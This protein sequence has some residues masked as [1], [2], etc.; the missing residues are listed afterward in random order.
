MVTT[1]SVELTAVP[2]PVTT[3]EIFPVVAPAGTVVTILVDVGVPDMIAGVP[4]KLTALFADIV[5][6][7]VPVIV[8]GVASGP[9]AG[10]KLVIVGRG[11]STTKLVELVAVWPATV[12]EIGPVEAVAGTDVVTVV[13]VLAVTLAWTPLNNT[14]LFAGVPLKFVPVIV[15]TVPSSPLSGLKPVIVG[16]VVL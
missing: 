14:I 7:F 13:V 8:T 16:E 9:V 1:K 12:I 4:L 15:T 6:K 3:T 11:R 5:E 10:L 2:A